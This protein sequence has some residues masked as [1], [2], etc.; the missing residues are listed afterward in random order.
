MNKTTSAISVAYAILPKGILDESC[1][2]SFSISSLLPLALVPPRESGVS[3]TPMKYQHDVKSRRIV[4]REN[5]IPGATALTR[6]VGQSFAHAR[7]IPRTACLEV[8]Y[9]ARLAIPRK[10]APLAMFTTIPAGSV[11]SDPEL[12]PVDFLG[13]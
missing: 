4:L 8:Q 2:A 7:V 3:V 13:S 6:K 1:A 9:A 12:R 5:H 10:E 11:L